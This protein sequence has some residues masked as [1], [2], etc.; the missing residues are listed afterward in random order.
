[1]WLRSEEEILKRIV[2]NRTSLANCVSFSLNAA[3]PYPDHQFANDVLISVNVPRAQLGLDPK[4]KPGDVDLLIVPFNDSRY[5]FERSVAIEVKV[6]RP[7]TEKP[8]RNVNSM[9]F[10]QISGLLRDGFRRSQ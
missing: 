5:H 8:S 1:M 4:K 2:A 7:T 6:L 3:F 9:G 10:K